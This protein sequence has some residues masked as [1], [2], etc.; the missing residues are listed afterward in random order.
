[1]GKTC[2]IKRYIENTFSDE[3]ATLGAQFYSKKLKAE[4][5]SKPVFD[6]AK[7]QVSA[8]TSQSKV[9][10][11]NL[12]VHSQ[13]IKLHL[14]DTAGE[15]RFRSLTPLYYKDA[16]AILVAFS[17]TSFESFEN[18]SKWLKEID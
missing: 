1:M 3:D 7:S 15:E 5:T 8:M 17:L 2:L 18:L 11:P 14:W 12:N 9:A 10:S 4:Y 6:D 16:Q 13:D